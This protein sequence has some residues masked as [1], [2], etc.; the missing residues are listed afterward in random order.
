MAP[1]LP[2]SNAKKSHTRSFGQAHSPMV[3]DELV[4]GDY[5]DEDLF[6]K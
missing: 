3:I 1:S 4:D 6:M 2:E 5:E